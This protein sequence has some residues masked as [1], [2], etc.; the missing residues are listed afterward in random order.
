MIKI[1]ITTF[2]HNTDSKPFEILIEREDTLPYCPVQ[3]SVDYCKLRG[4][5]RA[6]Y[7]ANQTLHQLQFINLT[8][9]SPVVY[10][11][12]ASIHVDIKDTASELA[13]LHLW[14][15]RDFL[16]P[17]FALLAAGNLMRLNYTFALNASM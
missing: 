3:A 11:F 10:N 1:I 15:K 2:K 16:T 6:P 7:F 5:F 17:K 4:S 12:V 9:N 13:P 8:P 14:L